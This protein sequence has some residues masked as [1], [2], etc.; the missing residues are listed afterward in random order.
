MKLT[1]LNFLD[2]AEI[3][4]AVTNEIKKVEKEEFSADFQELYNHIKAC[5]YT[6][7]VYFD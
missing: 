6:N 1:G 2:V 7:G 5:I 3:E 4:E